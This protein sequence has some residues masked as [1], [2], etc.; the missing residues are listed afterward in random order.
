MQVVVLAGGLATRLRPLT[1]NVP[2]ALVPVAGRPFVDHQLEW[3]H[4]QG[5]RDVVF[6][7][8]FLG[9][10]IREHVRDGSRF[11][12]SVDYVDEGGDLR[13]TAGALR[14]AYDEGALAPAFGVL[15][16]DSYL[17]VS[18]DAVG[19]AYDAS[20][21]P[22]LMTVYRNEGRLDASNARLED[23]LVV[24]YEKGLPDPVGSGMHWI[25]YGFTVLD[26]DAVIATLPAGE[27]LDLAEVVRV[28]AAECQLAGLEVHDRFYEIG[29][30]EGL[31][32][33]EAVLS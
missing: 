12:L 16:G 26:R 27:M 7:I 10:R 31:R 21:L 32:E 2:K 6:C 19:R 29:S 20:G 24:H 15:Y 3:L 30:H 25:D 23:G 11:G 9:G 33:L 28:L 8:G 14:L 1:A 5:V 17:T 18:L 13:G 22:A 4:R